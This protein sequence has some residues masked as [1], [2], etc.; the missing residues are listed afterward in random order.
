[1][2]VISVEINVCLPHYKISKFY[3]KL[4]LQSKYSYR[5][6]NANAVLAVLS[7]CDAVVLISQ[8]AVQCGFV[9]FPIFGCDPIL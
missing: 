7:A 9:L 5:K 2:F 4:L 1:M 6:T 3:A 8:F